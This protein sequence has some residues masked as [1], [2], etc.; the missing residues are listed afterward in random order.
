[1]T[2]YSKL[3]VSVVYSSNADYSDPTY[4]SHISDV[5]LTPVQ[6]Y[7]ASPIS[8]STSG[9]TFTVSNF[10]T[11]S[12]AIIHNRDTTNYVTVAFTTNSGSASVSLH[13][14]AGLSLVLSDIKSSSSFT[15]TANTAAVVCDVVLI[16]T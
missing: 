4:V 11:L 7:A 9:Q 13:L 14:T 15:I 5:A 16:G 12:Q 10:T 2:D 1:M 8:C 3:S 6:I